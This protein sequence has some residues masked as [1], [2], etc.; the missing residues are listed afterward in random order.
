MS[1]STYECEEC[2]KLIN[3]GDAWVEVDI[4][5]D[6]AEPI[7]TTTAVVHP[8]CLEAYREKQPRNSSQ[9]LN[10]QWRTAD[11]PV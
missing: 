9:T 11:R 10:G 5:S 8:E 6:L 7:G 4:A 3:E 1:E 2:D